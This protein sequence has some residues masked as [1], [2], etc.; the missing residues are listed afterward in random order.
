M[1]EPDQ[2]DSVLGR[3]AGTLYRGTERIS[4]NALLNALQVD[5]DPRFNAKIAAVILS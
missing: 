4:S 5:P 3:I 2:W 1:L